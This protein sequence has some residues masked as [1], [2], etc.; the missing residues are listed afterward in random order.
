[1][2][3]ICV[4]NDSWGPFLLT[5]TKKTKDDTTAFSV[6]NF[7]VKEDLVSDLFKVAVESISS[8]KPRVRACSG[9]ASSAF[10]AH[11]RGDI[12]PRVRD[13]IFCHGTA[14]RSHLLAPTEL[15]RA[16][17]ATIEER[18]NFIFSSCC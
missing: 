13:R 17:M 18:K 12:S 16:T 3:R 14:F 11:D 4:T 5:I 15:K 9:D 2:F 6:F 1:M 10:R 7:N 8:I